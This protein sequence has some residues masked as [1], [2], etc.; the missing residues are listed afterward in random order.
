MSL[1]RAILGLLSFFTF[2]FLSVNVSAQA[3]AKVQSMPYFIPS[4]VSRDGSTVIGSLNG[5]AAVFT[6]TGPVD[7]GVGPNSY[8]TACSRDASVIV[9]VSNSMPFVLRAGNLKKLLLFSGDTTGV[10]KFVSASGDIVVGLSGT[11]WVQW[12]GSQVTALPDTSDCGITCMSDD[13]L[14]LGGYQIFNYGSDGKS[15]AGDYFG[16]QANYD[17]V[18]D[19]RFL[20]QG[21]GTGT[22]CVGAYWV[23][24]AKH[25]LSSYSDKTAVANCEAVFAISGDGSTLFGSHYWISLAQGTMIG[26]GN[27][28]TESVKSYQW[29]RLAG[30]PIE[31]KGPELPHFTNSRGTLIQGA[32]LVVDPGDPGSDEIPPTDAVTPPWPHGAVTFDSIYGPRATTEDLLKKG[33][34]GISLWNVTAIDGMSEDG[35]VLVGSGQGPQTWDTSWVTTIP[36]VYSTVTLDNSAPILG[37]DPVGVTVTLSAPPDQNGTL[38]LDSSNPY[39][40]SPATPIS[41]VKGGPIAYHFKLGSYPQSTQQSTTLT[42]TFG[43]AENSLLAYIFEPDLKSLKL[44][45]QAVVGGTA[46][47]VSGTLTAA[48]G[49]PG[50]NVYASSDSS[51]ASVTNLFFPTGAV[52]GTTQIFCKPVIV[53]TKVN[54][55]WQAPYSSQITQIT[56]LPAAIGSVSPVNTEV[57]GG[58]AVPVTIQLTGPAGPGGLKISFSSNSPLALV[59]SPVTIPAGATQASVYVHTLGVEFPSLTTVTCTAGSAKK[60]IGIKITPPQ[61]QS[62]YTFQPKIVGGLVGGGAVILKGRAGASGQ[63]ITLFADNPILKPLS[64]T[65]PAQA[66]TTRFT[67]TTLGVDQE[68]KV[69]I[70][71]INEGTYATT[72]VLLEPASLSA[73]VVPT[74]IKGGST[75]TGTVSLSGKAGPKGT[76]IA[77]TS[78]DPSVAKLQ[79]SVTVSGGVSSATFTIGTTKVTGLK[80]VTISAKTADGASKQ[81]EVSIVPSG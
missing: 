34:L 59:P 79:T 18:N 70:Y 5:R 2:G 4:G 29:R 60:S 61:I 7:L 46:I 48:P 75:V 10:P 55:T 52:T 39:A 26:S 28:I 35:R 30:A 31:Y 11:T 65:V 37:G 3:F 8:C 72:S 20:S 80:P 36:N 33:R 68:T 66:L 71:A 62:I 40:L 9:G 49:Y 41:V 54:V 50:I 73:V 17:L 16:F 12:S 63:L 23:S 69:S 14:V 53:P 78:S 42:A 57:V 77:L 32:V 22:G 76:V 74:V 58:L 1:L 13:G 24:G 43:D 6:Q 56:I 51:N 64:P 27:Y 45:S 38:S 81:V 21:S 15:G 44:S 25:L 47:Q 19:E 67:F